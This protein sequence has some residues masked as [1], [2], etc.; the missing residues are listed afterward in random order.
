MSPPFPVSSI[1]SLIFSL[2]RENKNNLLSLFFSFSVYRYVLVL[3]FVLTINNYLKQNED[4]NI[5][6]KFRIAT[7][8]SYISLIS[9][10]TSQYSGKIQ[11]MINNVVSFDNIILLFAV[12]ILYLKIFKFDFKNRNFKRVLFRQVL[13]LLFVLSLSILALIR[14]DRIQADGGLDVIFSTS[15]FFG[16][17]AIILIAMLT[18]IIG[19]IV[20]RKFK[21]VGFI[22]LSIGYYLLIWGE[23]WTIYV[24]NDQ[25][26]SGGFIIAAILG[27]IILIG[28]A[29]VIFLQEEF[30]Q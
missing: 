1:F 15:T 26:S 30:V 20:K 21:K 18:L 6:T 3:V 29:I 23:V 14:I 11:W 8:I 28:Y 19:N 24:S 27:F 5:S 9:L 16:F 12:G 10:F 4:T 2:V 22:S 7:G 13:S 25:L 17:V